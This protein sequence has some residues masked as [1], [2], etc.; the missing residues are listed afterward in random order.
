MSFSRVVGQSRA[1]GVLAHALAADRVA[2]AYLFHGPAGTGKR[3]A[4]LALSQALL[5]ERG[6]RTGDACGVCLACT[7]AARLIHPDL[8]VYLPF[9]K[10]STRAD[11]DERPDDYAERLARLSADPY[12]GSDYRHRAK[13]DAE[14]AP[15]KA[16]AHRIGVVRDGLIRTL[17]YAPSEGRHVVGVV[18]DADRMNEQAANAFL[19]M[20][21]EPPPAVVL[22]LTAERLDGL[23][24]TILS[25]CQRVRFD[26]LPPA[27]VEAALGARGM[28]P[29]RAAF[30][31]RMAGG[32]LTRA[33]ALVGSPELG[34]HR[35]L[36]LDFLRAAYTA[37]PE[38]VA[39]AVEAIA[40]LGRERIRAWLDLVRLWLRDLVHL[41]ET[42]DPSALVN[43]DQADAVAAFV[44]HVRGA[45]PDAMAALV[46][47]AERLVTGN[48]SAP[49]ALTAL[50]LGL[51]DAMRGRGGGRLYRPL[52]VAPVGRK[53]APAR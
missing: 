41:R 22:V 52:D 47:E 1:V 24:P 27:D 16:P 39:P 10:V 30:V 38:R 35:R 21:E 34:E 9:P 33:L 31:A 36:A 19:K 23:L 2:H 11:Q 48:V 29:E 28:A 6:A 37:R 45:D 32:S 17:G 5:C 44:Q 46:D 53:A 26:P 49:L 7:K 42:G 12:E 25:R 4:A 43:V 50:A 40:A 51:A 18:V 3:A 14:G 13:L 15:T 20:L 8:H